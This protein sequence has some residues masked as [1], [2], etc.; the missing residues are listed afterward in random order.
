MKLKS[1][2]VEHFKSITDSGEVD[3]AGNVICLVGK[4]ESGKTAFL[5]ALYRVNPQRTG[6]RLKFDE[7]HDFPRQ[8]R[9]R[10]RKTLGTLRPIA[11]C[12]PPA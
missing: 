1:A 4:N 5:E 8:R 12:A 2:Q 11:P 9:M 3:L 6:H 7:R 10:E